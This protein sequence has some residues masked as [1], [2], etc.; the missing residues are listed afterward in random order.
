MHRVFRNKS[1]AKVDNFVC[2]GNSLNE[3][4]VRNEVRKMFIDVHRVRVKKENSNV[5]ILLCFINFVY[6]GKKQYI[7]VKIGLRNEK[8]KYERENLN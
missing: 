8:K 7:I 2:C 3:N 5:E 6:L 1:C 4:E